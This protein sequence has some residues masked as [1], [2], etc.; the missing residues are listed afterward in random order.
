MGNI[1]WADMQYNVVYEPIA[2]IRDYSVEF[3]K[4]LEIDFPEKFN[5]LPNLQN[6]P[7]SMPRMMA[8]NQNGLSINISLESIAL[9]KTMLEENDEVNINVFVDKAILIDKVLKKIGAKEC[10]SGLILRGFLDIGNNPV[11]YIQDKFFKANFSDNIF[12]IQTKATFEIN[13]KYYLNITLGNMR[14]NEKVS[15]LAIE[16]DINDRY[17]YNFKREKYPYSEENSIINIKK[18][19]DI[20]LKNQLQKI[21]EKGDFCDGKIQSVN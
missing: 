8:S 3:E 6:A 20:F 1:K 4:S 16:L 17:R 14:K 18:I 10:F 15:F 13:E 7:Y 9:T 5:I 12:D 19:L 11:Q 21:I 2:D